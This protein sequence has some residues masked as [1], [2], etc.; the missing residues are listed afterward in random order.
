[1]TWLE[2]T[3]VVPGVRERPE[4][5]PELDPQERVDADRGLVEEQDR[6]PVDERAGERE[7][8]P[9]PAGQRPGD[10]FAPVGELHELERVG[11]PRV[12]SRTP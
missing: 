2:T 10:R 6:R 8:A 12:R 11:P 1:M 3:I 9:L 4:V 5:A 7:P